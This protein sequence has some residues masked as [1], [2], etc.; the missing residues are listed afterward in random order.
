ADPIR[1]AAYAVDRGDVDD[2]A[3]LPLLH[4]WNR[5][6]DGVKSRGEIHRQ[7]FVPFRGAEVL[8]GTD[9]ANDGVVDHDVDRTELV[10]GRVHHIG[11]RLGLA[12]IGAAVQRAYA[13]PP[14]IVL[15]GRRLGLGLEAVED[16]VTAVIGEPLRSGQSE[17]ADRAGNE[18]TLACE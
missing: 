3:P 18:R 5:Q 12:Q 11:D 9:V 4:L 15:D 7:R 6:L 1:R 10:D 16:N 17:T 14:Q 8:D 2:A 13:A